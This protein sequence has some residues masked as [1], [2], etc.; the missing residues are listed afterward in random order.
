[1]KLRTRIRP[2]LPLQVPTPAGT[3]NHQQIQI[4]SLEEKVRYRQPHQL[5]LDSIPDQL[6]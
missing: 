4:R 6:R 5:Y 1:M 2:A 3:L